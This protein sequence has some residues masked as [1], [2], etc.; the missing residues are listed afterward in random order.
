MGSGAFHYAA[1]LPGGTV[2]ELYP[3]SG[4]SVGGAACCGSYGLYRSAEDRRF[5]RR[6]ASVSRSGRGAIADDADGNTVGL[7]PAADRKSPGEL[8][9]R[10][11]EL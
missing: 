11:L 7:L 10:E 2:F 9:A 6:Y 8:F 4:R 5:P 3:S 1:S